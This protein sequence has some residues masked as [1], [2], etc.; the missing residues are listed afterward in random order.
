[1]KHDLDFTTLSPLPFLG[2]FSAKKNSGVDDG[3]FMGP[4]SFSQ[5]VK[6]FWNLRSMQ[7]HLSLS[8]SA[9][10]M[11]PSGESVVVSGSQ[12]YIYDSTR[13]EGSSSV[14]SLR[15]A[16]RI[17]AGEMLY[18]RADCENANPIRVSGPY[19]SKGDAENFEDGEFYYAVDITNILHGNYGVV[20]T[21]KKNYNDGM[22]FVVET[23]IV[24]F[25]GDEFEL[26]VVAD[27]SFD[28]PNA[29]FT[30]SC[31]FGI[32]DIYYNLPEEENLLQN[33]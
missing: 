33:P 6:I 10:F 30:H 29:T 2:D 12:G 22:R 18:A 27:K 25:L 21:G 17:C 31:Q 4:M 3:Y 7:A 11:E 9:V 16:W 19:Y 8:Y 32:R 13:S 20:T 23:K 1:M 28:A 24:N 5:A 26:H 15:P 14:L